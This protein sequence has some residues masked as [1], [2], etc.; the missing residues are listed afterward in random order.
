MV[1]K[2]LLVCG[3]HLRTALGRTELSDGA[4]EEVDLIVEVDD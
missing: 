1:V 4:I 3:L 2:S